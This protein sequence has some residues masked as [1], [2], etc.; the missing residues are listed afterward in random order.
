M[1]DGKLIP[2]L[3]RHRHRIGRYYS[4][5]ILFGTILLSRD[6][7]NVKARLTIYVLPYN[8]SDKN[9]QKNANVR[10]VVST[11]TTLSSV[12]LDGKQYHDVRRSG[13]NYYS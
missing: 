4:C 5:E 12:F 2:Y 7:W 8:L 6:T 13:G 1:E 10:W 9:R 3:Y 11:I